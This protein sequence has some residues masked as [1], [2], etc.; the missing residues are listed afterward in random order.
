M[1]TMAMT[2]HLEGGDSKPQIVQ[3]RMGPSTSLVCLMLCLGFLGHGCGSPAPS[4]SPAAVA[5]PTT[6]SASPAAPPE[7]F[8][9]AEIAVLSGD[10]SVKAATSARFKV[11]VANHGTAPWP[12]QAT[13]KSGAIVLAYHLYH[14]GSDQAV[15][16]DGA[17]TLLPRDLAPG[18]S[19]ELDADVMA[20]KERGKYEVQFDLVQEGV[21][22]FAD[23]KSPPAPRVAIGVN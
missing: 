11:R 23:R 20:P 19:V 4:P 12:A 16:F 8:Y 15:V 13:E 10:K 21:A 5:S 7:G 9:K 6:G 22:W 1:R 2:N 17:R 3:W 18:D 14:A